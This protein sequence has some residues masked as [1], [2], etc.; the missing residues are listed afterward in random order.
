[1]KVFKCSVRVLL[2]LMLF[3]TSV[4][5]QGVESKVLGDAR[6]DWSRSERPQLGRSPYSSALNGVAEGVDMDEQ[7]IVSESWSISLG[8]KTLYR[9]MRRWVAQANYQLLWQVDRDF[10]IESEVVFRGG[11]R[12]AVAE[13]MSGVSR[14]DFPLQAIFNSSTRVLRVIRYLDERAP[15][16][17]R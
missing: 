11:L 4:F 16:G 8:D 5:G 17:V 15:D 7:D 12:S 10:P 2:F 1:M 9:V 14:T 3:N 13:V 6:M